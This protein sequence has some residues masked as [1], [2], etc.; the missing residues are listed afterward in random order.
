MSTSNQTKTHIEAL[1]F[2]LKFAT[3]FNTRNITDSV[4]QNYRQNYCDFMKGIISATTDNKNNDTTIPIR[5]IIP[6]PKKVSTNRKL[7]I[8]RCDKGG[9]FVIMYTVI[10]P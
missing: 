6:T 2:G 7:H 5:H 4:N 8:T 9:R 1:S 3:G 10:H